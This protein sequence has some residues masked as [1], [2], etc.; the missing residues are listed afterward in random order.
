M[1][2]LN[3][4][5]EVKMSFLTTFGP[6][7]YQRKQK[8]MAEKM[9]VEGHKVTG[10]ITEVKTCWWIKINTKAFRRHAL[11][12][13]KFP[14]IIYFTYTVSGA[15]YRGSCCIDWHLRCPYKGEA[16]TVFY[17]KGNPAKYTVNSFSTSL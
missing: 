3:A 8:S 12:G 16:V 14:H 2:I 7:S 10:S 15:A 13:G 4:L 1:G 5:A 6:E 11:D 9:A 17:D